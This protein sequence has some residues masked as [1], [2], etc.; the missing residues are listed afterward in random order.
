MIIEIFYFFII[1][2]NK[3]PVLYLRISFNPKTFH[4]LFHKNAFEV[5]CRLAKTN[6]RTYH[7]KRTLLQKLSSISTEKLQRTNK[8][9]KSM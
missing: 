7:P 4:E 8:I 6:I 1:C 3:N 2:N 5:A 9:Q